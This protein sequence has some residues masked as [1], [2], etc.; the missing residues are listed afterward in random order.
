MKNTDLQIALPL[1][2][3]LLP[4]F[5]LF[6]VSACLAQTIPTTSMYLRQQ[7]PG[8][9]PKVFQLQVT[10]GLAAAERI[11]ITSDNREIYYG[12]LDN[13]PS[14]VQ[15]IK[16]YKYSGTSWQGP[17][18][19]FEGYI[20]PSL[21]A[22]DSIMYMQKNLN[23]NTLSCTFYSLRNSTGWT[24]PQRLLSMDRNTHY[25]QETNQKNFFTASSPT[26]T[27]SATDLCTLYIR[28]GDTTIQNLGIPINTTA[29]ENDFFISRDESY[30]IFCRFIGSSA[31]DLFITYKT[32][33]G[34]WTNPK[35]LGPQVNIP[36]PNWEACPF[37]T[38]DNKYLFFMRGGNAL[39]SYFIYWVAIDNLID[40]LRQ[41]NFTPYVRYSLQNQTFKTG[42]SNSFAIPDSS[43]IDDN[44]NN[45]LTYTASLSNGNPL[46]SWLSFD[47][48]SGNFVGTPPEPGSFIVKVTAADPAA[49]SAM[50]SFTLRVIDASGLDLQSLERNIE[51]FPNPAKDV[52]TLS[53]G[54]VIFSNAFVSVTDLIGKEIFSDTI[55]NRAMATIYLPGNLAGIYFVRINVDGAIVNKKIFLE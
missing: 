28:N 53:L 22:N 45:T 44:G 12:E 17:F 24:V 51:V 10:P 23:N 16:Y 13:W 50:S 42:R 52:I 26:S 38:K 36:N 25:F 46:P 11:A 41:T 40:S 43:F 54:T 19:V 39:S 21:S 15:R 7:V 29:T 33:N 48:D 27:G 55:H 34:R 2:T 8:I 9:T 1:K 18:V 35:T 4:F 30:I 6:L 3:S 47:P 14:T 5:L 49:V 31:S 32:D 37:V 20:A